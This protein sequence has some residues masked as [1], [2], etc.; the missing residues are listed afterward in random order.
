M[1]CDGRRSLAGLQAIL[2][3]LAATGPRARGVRPDQLVNLAA[4]R[5][6]LGG[7]F[8]KQLYGE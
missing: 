6:V 2:D 5:E 3:D 1:R 4:L 7:D 8:L